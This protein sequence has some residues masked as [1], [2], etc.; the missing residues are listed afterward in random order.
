MCPCTWYLS[1]WQ[2]YSEYMS[3]GISNHKLHKI[4]SVHMNVFSLYHHQQIIKHCYIHNSVQ[5]CVLKTVH[6]LTFFRILS[7]FSARWIFHFS[8]FMRY[9][10]LMLHFSS[11]VFSHYIAHLWD[12]MI[13]YDTKMWTRAY[14]TKRTSILPPNLLK[15]QSREIGCH[16]HRIAPKFLSRGSGAVE[17]PVKFQSDRK[18]LNPNLAASKLYEIFR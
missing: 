3:A 11:L 1:L 16:I 5:V 7:I 17:V 4:Q 2:Q 14:I 12:H 10:M 6:A 18:S 8:S 9:V 15:S 13:D